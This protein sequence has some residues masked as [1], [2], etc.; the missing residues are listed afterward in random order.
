VVL[1]NSHGLS[2]NTAV[3]AI[4][5]P[6]PVAVD[7]VSGSITRCMVRRA[8]KISHARRAEAIGRKLP[9]AR[10]DAGARKVGTK[11]VPVVFDQ[12]TA[13]SLLGRLCSGVG[14]CPL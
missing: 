3:P 4:R 12:E 9:S 8:A 13:G 2:E 7:P 6:P 14:V 10:S 5:W 1:G 11:R